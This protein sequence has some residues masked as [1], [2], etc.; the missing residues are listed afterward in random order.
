MIILYDTVCIIIYIYIWNKVE[1]SGGVWNQQLQYSHLLIFHQ[2]QQD[3]NS[4]LRQVLP[5]TLSK[6]VPHSLIGRLPGESE[7]DLK[8][9][10]PLVI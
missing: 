10:Y 4:I 1:H 8:L 5:H 6:R 7:W 2:W 9:T 3:Q